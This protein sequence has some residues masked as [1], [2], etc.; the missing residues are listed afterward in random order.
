MRS[1]I[2][3]VIATLL[4]LVVGLIAFVVVRTPVPIAIVH[5]TDS[6]SPP[7]V[8][9]AFRLRLRAVNSCPDTRDFA[10]ASPLTFLLVSM[11]REGVDAAETEALFRRFVKLGCDI[12]GISANGLRPIH[13]A[14]LFR[15]PDLLK[16]VI[17]LGARPEL[18]TGPDH[19][20]NPKLQNVDATAYLSTL[21]TQNRTH[22][23]ELHAILASAGR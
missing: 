23:S 17:G 15:R 22:C 18:R 3:Q 8:R 6:F 1:R 13:V 11:D 16:L 4:A 20:Y 2:V 12:N 14:I 10:P 21:C 5:A 9:S 19:R 7:W